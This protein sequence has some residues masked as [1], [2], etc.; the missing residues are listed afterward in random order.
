[1]YF[2]RFLFFFSPR[3][4][5]SNLC[6]WNGSCAPWSLVGSVH[7]S[8]PLCRPLK[9]QCW[10][11]LQQMEAGNQRQN[12]PQE[13]RAPC[14]SNKGRIIFLGFY[15]IK[16]RGPNPSRKLMDRQVGRG[17][18]DKLLGNILKKKGMAV[19][20]LPALLTDKRQSTQSFLVCR[21]GWEM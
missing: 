15:K 7:Q 1:M 11:G 10:S 17:K 9:S 12:L 19:F 2:L 13:G 18:S 14:G 20:F 6:L 4:L 8:G 16:S 3:L 5:Y 21:K